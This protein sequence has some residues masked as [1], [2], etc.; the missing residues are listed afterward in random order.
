M[1]GCGVLWDGNGIETNLALCSTCPTKGVPHVHFWFLRRFPARGF[2]RSFIFRFDMIADVCEGH[3]LVD[4]VRGFFL[5]AWHHV[6]IGIECQGKEIS[7]IN[8]EFNNRQVRVLP[9]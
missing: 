8:I 2:D 9:V 1:T 4:L 3:Q 7:S 5:E 6:G